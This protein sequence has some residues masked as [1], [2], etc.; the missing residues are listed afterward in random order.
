VEQGIVSAV[1]P[2]CDGLLGGQA[3]SARALNLFKVATPMQIK[4]NLN[5]HALQTTVSAAA[6]AN[7]RPE[8]QNFETVHANTDICPLY[9]KKYS[10]IQTPLY[11]YFQNTV[12]S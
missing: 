8:Q 10:K 1:K 4:V 7:K 3:R 6:F 11:L 5:S 2:Q 12:F 9:L